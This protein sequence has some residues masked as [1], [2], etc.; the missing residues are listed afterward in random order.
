MA[1]VRNPILAGFHPDPCWCAARGR[2]YLAT[3][4]FQWM[5]GVSLYESDDLVQWRPIGGA[6]TGLDLRGIPDSAGVWAPDLTFDGERFWLVYTVA[7]QIDGIFKDVSNYVVTARDIEGPWSAPA[8][9]NASGFDPGLYHEDG[10]HYVLNP[11]WDPRPLPGHHR[12]NGLILQEFALGAGSAPNGG[13]A[14]AG[15]SDIT[16]SATSR[17]TLLGEARRVLDNAD[18]VNWLREG[19]HIMKHDGWY[20]IAC[21]EGGTGRRHRIRMARSRALWGPYEVAPEPLVCAWCA[22]TPLRKAGHGNFVQTPDGS[23]YVCHLTARY[24]PARS[25]DGSPTPHVYDEHEAGR[26]P[27]GRET[28]MQRVVWRDGWPHLAAGGVAPQI[29]VPVGEM[30][31]AGSPAAAGAVAPQAARPAPAA[32]AAPTPA[33]LRP[34]DPGYRYE[35]R[36]APGTD[37]A[38][39]EWLTPRRPLDDRAG[40][41]ALTPGGLCLAGGD[42]PSSR[43]DR[44]S[45]SR[46]QTSFAYHAE[47]E[48]AGF[49]PHHYNQSA[50]LI[51][52]YD[53]RA[54]FYLAVGWDEERGTRV[55]DVIANDNDTFTMPLGAATAA[56]AAGGASA[57]AGT[58][59]IPV[60]DGVRSVTLAVD[61][62]DYALTFSYAFDG[63]ALG[64]VRSEDGDPLALDASVLSDEHVA[65]WTYTGAMVGITCV[66]MF[67]K[68][69][70]A[71][72]ARFVY[73]DVVPSEE[74]C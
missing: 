14:C 30:R 9:I 66:D 20:Y 74:D 26:S 47:T 70:C 16:P 37:L 39:E 56:T 42:S 36:F 64:P 60:P 69:A 12:F 48:L 55:I 52:E 72:F 27:L 43:F 6:L 32:P 25:Q 51:C 63:A 4:T 23:W 33:V 34:G 28:A 29:E 22:D 21:A 54:F 59:R 44:A 68:T 3:S 8:F 67:D 31:P 49:V 73:E 53:A 35:T 61:V 11:Q 19:P 46:R 10:R 5:P 15:A 40:W 7:R 18:A 24:L 17:V 71:T 1:T 41:F 45:V 50:G 65:G 13:S 57:E 58:G 2:Y 62:R 38:R